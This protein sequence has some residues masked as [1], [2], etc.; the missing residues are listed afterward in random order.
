MNFEKKIFLLL[1]SFV[2][3]RW[4]ALG[5]A[6]GY[7]ER[8]SRAGGVKVNEA[9]KAQLRK[10]MEARKSKANHLRKLVQ[11]EKVGRTAPKD[12]V[13][14]AWWIS[15]WNDHVTFDLEL[16][17]NFENPLGR[18]WSIVGRGPHLMSHLPTP[19]LP[20]QRFC[21]EVHAEAEAQ[22]WDFHKLK[23]HPSSS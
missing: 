3:L 12:Y 10:K 8:R 11:M 15:L 4:E 18:M 23:R 13:S 1:S 7:G 16:G 2:R 20:S 14:V 9:K 21:C 17:C 5:H 22:S 19:S 6:R